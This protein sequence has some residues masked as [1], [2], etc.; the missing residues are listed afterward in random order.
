LQFTLD[1]AR[2]IPP[3]D[4]PDGFVVGKYLP[5]SEAVTSHNG[6]PRRPRAPAVIRA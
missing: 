3:H 5:D 2:R 6:S 1:V 4:D